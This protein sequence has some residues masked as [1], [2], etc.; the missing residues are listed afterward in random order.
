MIVCYNIMRI[1]SCCMLQSSSMMVPYVEEKMSV[2]CKNAYVCI[3]CL[4]YHY[5]IKT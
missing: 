3:I 5:I 2:E 1:T 4:W